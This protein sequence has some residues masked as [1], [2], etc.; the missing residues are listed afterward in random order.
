MWTSLSGIR[1]HQQ[2][3]NVVGENLANAN[4]AGFKASNVVFSDMMNMT[5]QPAVGPA[6]NLGGTNPIQVGT[7][8][9]VGAISRDFSQGALRDT[10]NVM[11]LAMN[12]NGFMVLNDGTRSVYS[13]SLTASVDAGGNLV[14]SVTG[15][16]LSGIDGNP[17]SIPYDVQIPAQM[18]ATVSLSG[19]LGAGTAVPV[20]EV[21]A[22]KA[23]FTA[24]GAPASNATALNA[25][26]TT[27]TP[28][29]DGDVITISGTKA[30]GSTLTPATF[31]YGASNDGSTLGALVAK[32]NAAYAGQ[33]TATL[34][35]AGKIT[36]TAADAGPTALSLSLANTSGAGATDWT[37]HS[38]GVQVSGVAG[39]A[40]PVTVTVF[41]SRGQAHTLTMNFDRVGDSE[42]RINASLGD[43]QG[44]L[45]QSSIQGIRFN[46]DGSLSS[47]GAAVPQITIDYGGKA[48]TQTITLAMGTMGKFDGLTLFAGASTVTG[49][50]D[51][52]AAGVLN[53]FSFKADGSVQGQ[54]TNGQRR[55]LGQLQVATFDNVQGLES[56]G[57]NQW[58][59]TEN[60]GEPVTG[61]ALSGRAGSVA[62]SAQEGSNVDTAEE[63]SKLIVAQYGFQI[64]SRAM[65]VSSRV[66]EQLTQTI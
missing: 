9:S 12:G 11:D 21:L 20:R 15:Y 48:A 39:G 45:T 43:S 64:S 32:I 1:A 58:V 60:S 19:N 14:D 49:G 17:V 63:L 61:A 57:G 50:Q 29:V 56:V 13:R 62:S 35:A 47:T 52:Y 2:M 34:D 55:V 42:W 24:S 33:A 10:G 31:T 5:L 7:G 36:L 4:T 46:T 53:G 26:D 18:S 65:S 59:A 6:G 30:D 3:L 22:S 66:M 40:T 8:V 41:D 28:Y 23:A 27:G 51:G 44:V 16:R 37:G 54:Y 38:F 25:I